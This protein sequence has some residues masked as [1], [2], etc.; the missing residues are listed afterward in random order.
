M[1]QTYFRYWLL[2]G[3]LLPLFT[4]ARAGPLPLADVHLHWK[5]NQREVTTAEQAIRVLSDANI[6]LAVVSG[7]PPQL[8][9]ELQQLAPD[10]VVPIY[11]LYRIPGEWSIWHRDD[12]LLERVRSALA[13]GRYQGIGEVH[14]I[15]GFISDWRKPT[16]AGLFELA[17]EFDVPVLVHTEFSRADYTLGFCKAHPE[18]AVSLGP[19]RIHA[20]TGRGSACA[21]R[22]PQRPGRV[23]GARSVA[24]PR[25]SYDR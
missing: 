17:A 13:S 2:A 3:L 5:W 15:G 24:P 7:T 20:Q 8:A 21:Q 10:I 25:Q 6:E 18:N 23:I 9:L 19:C 16:I 14:M 1:R 11:G 22:L 4:S 12:G